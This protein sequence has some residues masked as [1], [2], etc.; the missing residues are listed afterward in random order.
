VSV[1]PTTAVSDHAPD[2]TAPFVL[3]CPDCGVRH[4]TDRIDDA[5]E[6]A[7]THRDHT[8]HRV[9]WVNHEFGYEDTT[10][11][12][13]AVVCDVCSETWTFGDPDR[14]A[15]WADEHETYTDHAPDA[16]ETRIDETLADGADTV[17]DVIAALDPTTP[18]SHGVPTGLVLTECGRVGIDV[19]GAAAAIHD[20]LAAGELY[21][22]Q[23]GELKLT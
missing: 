11:T 1:P 16:P 21:E 9:A 19:T 8:G 3:D 23:A 6:F 12:V 14:A 10:H 17:R 15:E 18:R 5:L 13:H 22:P 4:A 2:D 20:G 7:A